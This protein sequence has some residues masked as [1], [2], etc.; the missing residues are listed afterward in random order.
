M[1]KPFEQTN[2]FGL[3]VADRIEAMLAYWD[4]DLICRFANNAYIEW[5]GKSK[6]DMVDKITMKELLG[7]LYEKNLPYITEV[8][9]GNTQ[10]FEREIK[11]PGGEIRHSLANY[12]PDFH[13]GKVRGFS[14]H[15]ADITEIKKVQESIRDSEERFRTLINF[16]PAGI[17]L[18]SMEGKLLE[19]N[20]TILDIYGYESK[21]EFLNI[22]LLELYYDKMD[23]THLLEMFQKDG[24]LNNYEVR[25]KRKNGE[26]FWISSN[27][28]IFRMPSGEIVRLATSVDITERKQAEQALKESEDKFRRLFNFSPIGKVLTT[29]EGKLL[30]AN[31]AIL[32]IIGIDSLE[33][34]ASKPAQEYYV[35]P[36]ERV[37]MFDLFRKNGFVKEFEFEVKKKNGEHVWISNHMESF[38]FEKD[39]KQIISASLDITA[40]KKAEESLHALNHELEAF[41]YSVAHDLRAPLR[42]V[43]GYA[44]ILKQDYEKILDVE[45]IR[46]I[47]NIKYYAS[48]MGRL[49]DDLLAFSRLGRK[50][51]QF[52]D[53]NMNELT[54]EVLLEFNKSFRH[55]AKISVGKLPEVLGDYNLLS[56]VMVNL[57]SNAVKYSS[58]I[59]KPVIQIF[60]E[61]QNGEIIFSVKD[62]GA[63]FDMKYYDKLFGVFQRLH[64]DKEFEGTGIGLALVHRVI[65]KHGG[66]MWA[67][68]KVDE[69]ATFSFTLNQKL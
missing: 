66:K 21:E 8:L 63:G 67:E 22:S 37:K 16:S 50:E 30:D 33:E 54:N 19:A 6:E 35:D 31:P 49:I 17:T 64:A 44:E 41:S 18:S 45:G 52:N 59:E 57:I 56:Q 46:I 60:S 12:Y 51:I 28:H 2:D 14:V 39:N 55:N 69:G 43:N 58:K 26:A 27:V 4:K 48:K 38:S 65:T 25:Q 68:G 40:R 11:T 34:L 15:V 36:N 42:S 53:V 61:V 13:E 9:K 29:A 24:V 7:H 5:F 10:Q 3:L 62:N 20:Q 1:S 32:K 23:R 47:E